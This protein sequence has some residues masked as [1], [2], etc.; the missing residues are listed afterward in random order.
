M[1]KILCVLLLQQTVLWDFVFMDECQKN[2]TNVCNCSVETCEKPVCFTS[3]EYD[4]K[5]INGLAAWPESC[6]Q[7]KRQSPIHI[8]PQLYPQDEPHDIDDVHLT[9]VH[10]ILIDDTPINA[11]INFI[12]HNV[13][14]RCA[15]VSLRNTGR[16]AKFSIKDKSQGFFSQGFTFYDNHQVETHTYKFDNG[17]FHW[18][19]NDTV[20]SEHHIYRVQFPLELH[21]VHF[22]KAYGKTLGEAV[23]ANKPNSLSVIGIMFEL[24]S[25]PNEMLKP[26]FDALKEIKNE[27]DTINVRNETS[28][29]RFSNF[30][31]FTKKEYQEEDFYQY[32]GSLTTPNC[33]EIVHWIVM[34][35]PIKI[36]SDQMQLFRELK[37]Q[38]SKGERN[39]IN[40]Y[41]P[42]QPRNG[43]KVFGQ[44]IDYEDLDELTH[45]RSYH[46]GYF[47][48]EDYDYLYPKDELSYFKDYQN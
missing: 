25:Q 1:F 36:S 43:R 46:E 45:L 26:F 6:K 29:W 37:F 2:L 42:V 34:K 15:Q 20:G 38:S 8:I 30:L 17:H 40:N 22:N 39:I 9:Y 13:P 47:L 11:K 10:D 7:G 44:I 28:Q 5:N 48:D 35:N 31:P 16:T 23:A 12:N 32:Y 14:L 33:N 18:G 19:E 27:G 4:D 3:W 24:S 21:L 41:R